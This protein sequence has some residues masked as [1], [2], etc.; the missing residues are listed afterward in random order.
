MTLT[1]NGAGIVAV[2]AIALPSIGFALGTSLFHRPPVI[3][4]VIGRPNEFPDYTYVPRVITIAENIG[5]AG[6]AT[7]YV[8]AYNPKIDI[9]T[10]KFHEPFIALSNRCMH[11]GCPVKY[12]EA[13]ERFIC[14][15]HGGVYGFY[16]QVDGGPPVR[17]LDRFYTRIRDGYVEVGPRYSVNNAFER[18]PSY[19]DPGENL[20]KPLGPYVYPGRLST[21]KG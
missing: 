5:A 6:K 18:F 13:A 9:A 16:G 20:D 14:P 3:W 15:C 1:A 19:R 8:R 17:P 12:V 21:S 4:N 10:G 2:S 11:L 7:I